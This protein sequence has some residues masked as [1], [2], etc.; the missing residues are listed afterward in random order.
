MDKIW[1]VILKV[2]GISTSYDVK[3]NKMKTKA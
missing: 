1:V 3:N 2:A